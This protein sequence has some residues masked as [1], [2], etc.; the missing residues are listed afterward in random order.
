MCKNEVDVKIHVPI[1]GVQKADID[2]IS[3]NLDDR[4]LLRRRS[5]GE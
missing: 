2:Y 4:Y 3:D 1:D 5:S